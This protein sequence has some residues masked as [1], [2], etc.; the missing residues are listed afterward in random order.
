MNKW[1]GFF[2]QHKQILTLA[3][4]FNFFSSFGQTFFIS[5]FVPYWIAILQI[6]HTTFGSI[7]S[8][9]TVLSAILLSYFGKFIDCIDYKKYSLIV[10]LTLLSAM[11]LISQAT[12]PF[13]LIFALFLLRFLGQGLMSH[14]SSTGV[15]KYFDENRGKALGFSSLGH[16]AGQFILPLIVVLLIDN[17]G[18]RWSLLS[19]AV[20]AFVI[21]I[22]CL[23]TMKISVEYHPLLKMKHEKKTGFFFRLLR[24]LPFWIIGLNV[25]VAPMV[26]TVVLLYQ[27]LIVESKGWDLAWG[28]SS[29]AFF[30]IFGALA[31]IFSGFL[32]DRFSASTMFRLFLLPL[33]LGLILMV[34]SNNFYILP[35][36][37]ALLGFSSG[38]QSAVQTSTIVEI[39]GKKHLG[40][41]RS[42]FATMGVLG[43]ALGPPIFGSLF[44]RGVSVVAIMLIFS[45][46]T[47][48][49]IVFS[50]FL[51]RSS[52]DSL[53]PL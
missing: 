45:S 19:L 26:C 34:I 15:A 13:V 22:P 11:V 51:S 48:I 46:F 3:F 17:Y 8:I 16:P 50:L 38:L 27:R 18:W 33:L 31:M 42:Y 21:V 5:L 43:A 53:V 32:I 25:L 20:L 6:N 40:E 49:F 44:D 23:A 47:L 1:S 4:L 35:V 2:V 39:Y 12:Y 52:E 29:F 7:Y 10:F 36:F 14:A 30:A 37:Y 24:S 28:V 9:L 41:M